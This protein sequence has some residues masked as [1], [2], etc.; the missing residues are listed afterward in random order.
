LVLIGLHCG[1]NL[2]QAEQAEKRLS[3]HGPKTDQQRRQQIF[4]DLSPLAIDLALRFNRTLDRYNYEQANH[5]LTSIHE[6]L[7]LY[8]LN[9]CDSTEDLQ[10]AAKRFAEKCRLAR[11]D[12][13]SAMQAYA[14]CV[15]ITDQYHIA[16]PEFKSDDLEPALNRM[17]CEMWWFRK[18]KTLRLR[19]IET[20]SRSIE[21]VSRCRATYASDYTVKLKRQQKKQSRLYLSS[22]FIANE[23]GESYSLQDLADRSTSNPFIRRSEL[24][25]RIKGFEMFAGISGHVG[26]F[27]TLAT[28]SRMHA[29]LHQGI[30]NPNYDGTTTKQAHEYLTHL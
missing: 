19:T 11:L 7:C 21:L 29:C 10:Q 13:D 8:D 25:V 1:T 12:A 16:P 17:G 4:S 9:L 26:E 5:E 22:T 20:I 28:P 24:M 30:T 27:Y 14:E 18:I 23:N 3:Q 15:A 6:R 2:T